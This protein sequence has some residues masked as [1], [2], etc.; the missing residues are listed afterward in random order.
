MGWIEIKTRYSWLMVFIKELD[1][2]GDYLYG[3]LFDFLKKLI[4]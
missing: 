1:M 3:L 4:N 2:T